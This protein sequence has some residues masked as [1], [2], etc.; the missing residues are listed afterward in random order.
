MLS[1]EC[2]PIAKVGGLAD[3]VIGLS[4]SLQQRGH[5]VSIILPKYDCMQYEKIEDLK[6]VYYDLPVMYDGQWRANDVMSGI[7][8]GVKCFFID[9]KWH[10]H[11]FNRQTIYGESD[12]V[13]RFAYF[14][15][16]ALEF[17]FRTD[18]N[19]DIIHSHD[20]PTALVNV[21][22]REIYYHEGMT[23][24]RLV[25][26]VHNFA[27]QGISHLSVLEQ[28]GI[29]SYKLSSECYED[30]SIVNFMK[31]AIVYADYTTT[32]SPNYSNE[33]KF[34]DKGMGLQYLLNKYH[35]KFGGILNGI[36]ES[37]WDPNTDSYIENNYTAKNLNNKYKNK[38]ALRQKFSLQDDFKPIVAVV[39][40][41]VGQKG[42]HLIKHAIRYSL[43]EGAQFVLLGSSPE[44]KITHDF[45][46]I[47]Y[48]L[49][50]NNDCHLEFG[51]NEE[52]SHQVYAGADIIV[53]PS[54]F[55]PCGLTQLIAMRYGTIPVARL[56]GGLKDTVRDIEH[57][58]LPFQFR[59]G[60]TFED[61]DYTGLESALGRAIHDWFNQPE[62]FKE[63]IKNAMKADYSWDLSSK[64]YITIYEYLHTRENQGG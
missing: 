63:L 33:V 4:K 26:S 14:S 59:N 1:S 58:D 13:E 42:V 35:Y 48:Q 32:V 15:K 18:M 50:G 8:E 30:N 62:T 6:T 31:A 5:N 36:D 12:D 49:E 45:N 20:W 53:I 19:P 39:S 64:K 43:Q 57:S 28:A 47:K 16:A 55:E 3:V 54:L 23:N 52:L 24:P 56:T 61:T 17:I 46:E 9:A 11:Y 27:H 40:R 10:K 21:I 2:S 25:F 29:D 51:F 44:P 34:T 41:L 38:S 22:Q 37:Y 7:V 60:Y